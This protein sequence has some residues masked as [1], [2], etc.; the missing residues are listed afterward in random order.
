MTAKYIV[1][2]TL[3]RPKPVDSMRIGQQQ[4]GAG[5]IIRFPATNSFLL[6]PRANWG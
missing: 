2:S 4:E 6:Q 3:L 1:I 5:P